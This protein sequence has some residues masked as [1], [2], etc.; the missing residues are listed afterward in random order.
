MKR[1]ATSSG[2]R[3]LASASGFTLL[4][5]IIVL[6]I[7]AL[8]IGLGA[9]AAGM[10]ADEHELRGVARQAEVTFMQAMTRVLN[11]SAP[12]SVNLDA[13]AAGRK[14][15]VRRAGTSEFVPAAGQRMLLRPGGLC[16][17]ITLRWQQDNHWITATLDPLTASFNDLEDNL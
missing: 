2:L 9:S 17:P 3:P 6:A 12:Q 1:R 10:L 7:A 11:T 8:L 15:S 5:M 13:V 14:L 16:E 4:E